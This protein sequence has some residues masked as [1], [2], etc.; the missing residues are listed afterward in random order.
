VKIIQQILRLRAE[1]FDQIVVAWCYFGL[2]IVSIL[3]PEGAVLKSIYDTLSGFLS[4]ETMEAFFF[5]L[6][7]LTLHKQ[8][9]RLWYFGVLF[10]PL[11]VVTCA[12][13]YFSLKVPTASMVPVVMSLAFIAV[14]V[15][16]SFFQKAG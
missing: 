16:S 15:K 6:F 3:R 14:I 7:G 12:S 1:P 13:V 10:I 2:G 11:I 8:P 4:Y 5:C 9:L